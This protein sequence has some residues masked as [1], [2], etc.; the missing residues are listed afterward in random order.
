MKLLFKLIFLIII[1]VS[2]VIADTW[3]SIG[4]DSIK[5]NCLLNTHE[6]VIAGTNNGLYFL[7]NDSLKQW[8]KYSG[9]PDLPIHDIIQA[10]NGEIIVSAGGGSNSDG[11]YGGIDLLDGAPYYEFNLITYFDFPQAIAYYNDTLMVGSKNT[12]SYAVRDSVQSLVLGIFFKEFKSITI[13][14]YSFGVEVPV[15]SDIHYSYDNRSFLIAGYDS[16]PEPGEGSLLSSSTKSASTILDS[17]TTEI[18]EQFSGWSLSSNIYIGGLNCLFKRTLNYEI[19]INDQKR[20]VADTSF[21]VISTPN[22]KK[23]NHVTGVMSSPIIVDGTPDILISTD[24]GVFLK[25]YNDNWKEFGDIPVIPY[26]SLP[27]Y[28]IFNESNNYKDVGYIYAATNEG[29]YRYTFYDSTPITSSY[30]KNLLNSISL[31]NNIIKVNANNIN[32]IEIFNL[33]GKNI[34]SNYQLNSKQI[35]LDLN[36]LN[37]SNGTYLLSIKNEYGSFTK[38]FSYIR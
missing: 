29:V 16:S 35:N 26:F 33:A 13:P 23:V 36:H 32:S 6:S 8:I 25:D 11:I 9:V 5:V 28:R 21:T 30:N 10:G 12:L 37:I 24:D 34:Y 2:F 15:I 31:K 20:Q 14:D 27:V 22:N 3:Q 1:G 4:L 38:K 17:S 19:I 18:Y 7:D